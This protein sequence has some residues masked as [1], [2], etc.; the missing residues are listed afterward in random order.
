MAKDP[1][2]FRAV[3]EPMIMD[4]YLDV[5]E[6]IQCMMRA[7]GYGLTGPEADNILVECCEKHGA[8]LERLAKQKFKVQI[9]ASVGDK[10]LDQQETQALEQAGMRLFE[11]AADAN[12][13]VNSVML[14]VIRAEGATTEKLIR[15]D[16]NRRLEALAAQGRYLEPEV[17]KRLRTSALEQ[18]A[19]LGVNMEENNIGAILD[20]CLQS[21]S[22]QLRGSR[23]PMFV[24][25][26]SLA[27]VVVVGG[28]CALTWMVWPDGTAAADAP[29]ASAPHSVP[30]S[31]PITCD[32]TCKAEI[33]DYSVKLRVAAQ[34]NRYVTPADDC[35]KK[36]YA[37]LRERCA[38]YDDLPPA[39]K[40]KVA[41]G[42]S[43]WSWC[44]T[45]NTDVLRTVVDDYLRWAEAR[46]GGK[47]SCEWL[48]RCLEALP[49]N[50]RCEAAAVSHGCSGVQSGR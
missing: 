11:R 6:E 23:T 34:A 16:M 29:T 19:R 10:F 32:A 13:V 21:S 36:W 3:I 17:W 18:V 43:A 5:Q 40:R 37:A 41:E 9:R 45:D 49:G 33:K 20:D 35:V 15:E 44:D 12:E 50:E 14:E 28:F 4:G 1:D 26:G 48:G 30:S 42:E 7:S 46:D 27:A 25:L 2:G 24:A 47:P 8:V 39:D 38:V 31:A 22:L